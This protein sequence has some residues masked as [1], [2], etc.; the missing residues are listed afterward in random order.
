M[1]RRADLEEHRDQAL[2]DL[3]EL[4]EQEAAGEIDPAQAAQL[5]RRYQ[6]DAAQ[7][8][9]DLQALKALQ[10]PPA[11][12]QD[13]D[14]P[15]DR[16]SHQPPDQPTAGPPGT[17]RWPKVAAAGLLVALAGIAA[18]LLPGS[19]SPRPDGGFVTGNTVPADSGG[20]TQPSIREL[21]AVVEANPQVI[22]MRLDLAHRLLEE[23]RHTEAFDQYMAVLQARPDQPHP[24]ALS[25]LGWLMFLDGRAD[26]AAQLLT[27][28]LK[29][30]PEVAE[31]RWFLANVLLLG[32]DRPQAAIPHL[33][34]VLADP[35][36]N[37]DSRQKATAL[38][39][40]ARQRA[41]EAGGG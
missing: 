2:A 37:T 29:R 38:L 31:T 40:V 11:A 35:S 3:L 20:T 26:L 24:E 5:R 4:D 30:A 14:Q 32:Q 22:P 7:A 15:P 23:E 18:T 33:K 28:S 10:D 8:L 41:T 17:R 19:T 27:Q 36:L 13:T 16:G 21:Q 39:E 12:G 6:T 34:K 25:H 1:T 9:R